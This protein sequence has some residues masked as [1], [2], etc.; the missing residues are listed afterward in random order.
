MA[1][2]LIESVP[3]TRIAASLFAYCYSFYVI[4]FERRLYA[5]DAILNGLPRLH[6]CDVYSGVEVSYLKRMTYSTEFNRSAGKTE[7]VK[8]DICAEYS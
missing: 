5:T 6:G 2:R 3:F 8:Q 4:C 1:C 7:V